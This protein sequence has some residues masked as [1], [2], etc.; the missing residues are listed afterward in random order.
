VNDHQIGF[1]D[2]LDE[3]PLGCEIRAILFYP[4]GFNSQD[5]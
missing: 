2:G 4:A 5:R 1:P 3:A